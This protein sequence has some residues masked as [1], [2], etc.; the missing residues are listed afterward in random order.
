M[1]REVM[2]SSSPHSERRLQGEQRA[3]EEQ[4]LAIVEA[5]ARELN[6]RRRVHVQLHSSL[7]RDLGFDSLGLSELIM[8]CEKEF[9]ARLPDDLLGRL[10]TPR[11][12]FEEIVRSGGSGT[13]AIARHSSALP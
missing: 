4:V 10:E 2:N 9:R 1:A 5:L 7:Q 13:V 12:L 8:R 11:D 6:P 3:S